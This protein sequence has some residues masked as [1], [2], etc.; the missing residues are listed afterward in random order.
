MIFENGYGKHSHN[1][2]KPPAPG[3]FGHYRNPSQ[4]DA[5]FIWWHPSKE[6]HAAN[7]QNPAKLARALMHS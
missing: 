6:P 4:K 5:P 3:L 1:G 2:A 7:G